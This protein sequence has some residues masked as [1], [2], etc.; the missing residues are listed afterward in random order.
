MVRFD[1]GRVETRCVAFSENE[2]GGDELL[3]RSGIND[4]VLAPEGTVCRIDGLGC[5]SDECFCQ[6]PFPQCLYWAYYRR[7]GSNWLYSQQGAIYSI[8]RNGDVDGWSWGEGDFQ[9]GVEPPDMNFEQICTADSPVVTAT[10]TTQGGGQAA[11]P[12][13]TFSASPAVLTSGQ[14]STLTWQASNATTVTLDGEAVDANGSKQVCPAA[15]QTW[16]LLATNGAGQTTLQA[17]VQVGGTGASGTTQPGATSQ[18]TSSAAGLEHADPRVVVDS[19]A[20]A[21]SRTTLAGTAHR[22]PS[23]AARGGRHHRRAC[24]DHGSGRAHRG[25]IA[26]GDGNPLR[27]QPAPDRNA[28]APPRAGRGRPSH[29]NPDPGCAGWRPVPARR[30]RAELKPGPRHGSAAGS[31][32][33]RAGPF[34]LR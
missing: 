32:F 14:C 27:V 25:A 1:D 26:A 34:R 29:A 19:G 4:V 22:C 30:R 28:E 23:P 15:S 7:E 8:I 31:S 11:S 18:P 17:S 24:P 21:A 6:C 5:S 2:I 12:Q 33:Q 20:A 13:V 9:S 10:A 3:T 16:T